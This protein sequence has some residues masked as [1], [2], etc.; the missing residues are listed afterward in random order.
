[1]G[2][3][4]STPA[5]VLPTEH[6]NKMRAA[7]P[8]M[9]GKTVAV[10]GC[11]TGMGFIF[12]K[13]CVE[14]GAKVLMLNRPSGRA[15]E[16]LKELQAVKEGGSASLVPI[17][18]M[19]FESVKAA[20]EKMQGDLKDTGLDV[21]VNNAGIMASRDAATVDGCDIQMQTNHLSH[22]LL[23]A[24]VSPLLEKAASLRGES[25]V[26]N[27]SSGAYKKPPNPMEAKYLEK[28]GGNL[29]GDA[30]G[31]GMS[32]PRYERYQQSKLATIAFTYALHDKLQAAGL[33]NVKALCAHPG[34]SATNLQ[35]TTANDSSYITGFIM[36]NF[37]MKKAHSPEDGT[38]G[39]LIGAIT[40]D[41]KSKQ[42][43]GPADL[44][45]P[46]VLMP[47]VDLADAA[48]QELV[49]SKSKAVTG[50]KFSFEKQEL[51]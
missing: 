2:L 22:F 27:M 11:T 5:E 25:R 9:K 13:T 4:Y 1:M 43:Y 50:A 32:G 21:L 46:A 33:K 37:V 48:A 6:Y 41:V 26:V 42:F 23:T 29:G 15:D 38:Q 7:L 49:W 34:L 20:G 16:A 47:E 24:G 10:T 39:L 18:L 35:V 28:N 31:M 19:S 45:G 40:A 17:D 8:S 14:L 3:S 12:A 30:A 51:L 36:R 44:T